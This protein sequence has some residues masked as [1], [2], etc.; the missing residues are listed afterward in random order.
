M[1]AIPKS[2]RKASIAV[3]AVFV[4]LSCVARVRAVTFED[5]RHQVSRAVAT[6]H[7]LQTAYKDQYPSQEF[8]A[9]TIALLR[10]ELPA[11]ET[12][13]LGRQSV[14]VDNTWL[15]E[16]LNDYEKSSGDNARRV[17]LLARIDERLRALGE[18]LD[19]MQSGK[20]LAS[21]DENKTRL[22]EI[23]RRAEYNKQAEEGSAL[24]RLLNRFLRWLLRLFPRT[25]P[26]QPGN[27]MVLSRIAQVVVIGVSLAAIGFLIWKFAPRYL[28]N[29][30]KKKTKRAARI[31]LGERLE[32]DQ[33]AADLLAQAEALARSGDLRAAIRKAYIALLCELGDR[34]VISLAQHKTNRDYL[35]A[36]RDRPSLFS[37]MRGLTNIFEIHWYGLVAPGENDWNEFR[38][39]YQRALRTP[40]L[41]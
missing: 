19:E 32:P 13:L 29:R 33:T 21:K 2:G 34:K 17:E 23:L 9:A 38:N 36:V 6:T 41:P 8:V 12:V 1:S 40:D 30:Q 26:L 24:N 35:G 14:T 25:K 7:E 16:A 37:S 39:G 5:Y 15:Y 28:R 20:P 10:T 3:V 31:V 27:A 18:R 11:H 22:A 4:L